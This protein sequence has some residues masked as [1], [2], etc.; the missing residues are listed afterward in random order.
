MGLS[1]SVHT[2]PPNSSSQRLLRAA[3][4]EAAEG[5]S[6]KKKKKGKARFGADLQP[7]LHYAN[8]RLWGIKGYLRLLEVALITGRL[9]R[10]QFRHTNTQV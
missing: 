6:S 8:A 7:D 3:V 4:A 1:D 5:T 10:P 9:P 2:L